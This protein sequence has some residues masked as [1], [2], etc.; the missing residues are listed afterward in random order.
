MT[1]VER[2]VKGR[3]YNIW[4][5]I[6]SAKLKSVCCSNGMIADEDKYR[7]KVHGTCL[8]ENVILLNEIDNIGQ[9]FQKKCAF[10]NSKEILVSNSMWFSVFTKSIVTIYE[11]KDF[12]YNLL[13]WTFFFLLT[14]MHVERKCIFY[15]IGNWKRKGL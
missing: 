6:R 3:R 12:S 10:R 14:L 5:P 1:D 8:K 9:Y 15:S 11:Q 4:I 7:G 13:L 2:R